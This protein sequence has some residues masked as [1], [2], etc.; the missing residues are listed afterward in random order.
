[1]PV[2]QFGM[3]ALFEVRHI[4]GAGESAPVSAVARLKRQSRIAAAAEVYG[5]GRVGLG[6]RVEQPRSASPVKR[7]PTA[8]CSAG[9]RRIGIDE[10][11]HR[12]GQRHLTLVV[13]HET[14]RLLW[15]AACPDRKTM[16]RL[17][18][19]IERDGT[20]HVTVRDDGQAFDPATK[21]TGF[22]LLGTRERADLLNGT[23]TVDSA[24][25]QGATVKATFPG[26]ARPPETDL[27][28][29][30]AAQDP[31]RTCDACCAT[32]LRAE[33]QSALRPSGTYGARRSGERTRGRCRRPRASRCRWSARVLGLGS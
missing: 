30:R 17:L 23:L 33:R 20:I 8:I 27:L 28:D 25:G 2:V 31:L 10:I 19:V 6:D 21:T 22:G 32:S 7:E 26:T 24:P 12:K 1:M 16:E 4:A 11:S 14:S 18:E 5:R 15:A 3:A 29:R 9:L 13:D